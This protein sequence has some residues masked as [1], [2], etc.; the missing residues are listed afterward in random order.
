MRTSKHFAT[1]Y[2]NL[3]ALSCPLLAVYFIRL[4]A[5]LYITNDIRVILPLLDVK[6]NTERTCLF[7]TEHKNLHLPFKYEALTALFKDPVRTAQ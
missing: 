7:I 5:Y 6:H 2:S 4:I 3:K 1:K